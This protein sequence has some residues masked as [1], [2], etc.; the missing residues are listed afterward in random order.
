LYKS[1]YPNLKKTI[2]FRQRIWYYNIKE[3]DKSRT[4]I[5]RKGSYRWVTDLRAAQDNSLRGSPNR[6]VY[7]SLRLVK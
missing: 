4:E 1:T 7:S 3:R 5:N 6:G 2:D